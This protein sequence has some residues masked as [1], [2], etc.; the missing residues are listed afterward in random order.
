MCQSR[1]VANSGQNSW[2]GV[3]ERREW[4]E[5]DSAPIAAS[6]ADFTI[7]MRGSC[8]SNKYAIL[9]ISN[10]LCTQYCTVNNHF[11]DTYFT[12]LINKRWAVIKY[13]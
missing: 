10:T 11:G 8:Q 7:M 1:E 12:I 2:E 3:G 4:M 9:V 13:L 6:W 5:R